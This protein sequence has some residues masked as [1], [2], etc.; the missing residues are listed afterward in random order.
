MSIDVIAIGVFAALLAGVSKG[1]FG[2]GASFAGAA[3]LALFVSPAMALG[4]ML[5]ILMLIDVATLRPYW[6][7]WGRVEVAMLIL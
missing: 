7:Q 4:I 3:I 6:R 5:P 1:G 2:S